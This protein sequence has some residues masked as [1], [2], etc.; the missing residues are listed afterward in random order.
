MMTTTQQTTMT[1]VVQDEY[2]AV[3]EDVLRVVDVER[4]TIDDN[5]VLVAV[6]AAAVD[7]G[8]WHVMAGLPLVG[9]LAFGLRSPRVPVPG[10]DLAG[11]IEAVGKAVTGFAP[12]DEVFGSSGGGSGSFAEY[13]V[14]QPRRLATKPANLSFEQAAAVPI[15]GLTALQAV[16]D[17]GRVQAGM[18]VAVVGASGGVGSYAVQIAKAFGA[19]VTGVA[20]TA[21]LDHVRSLG[22]EHVVDYTREDF[23]DGTVQYDVII[24][25]GGNRSLG[26]LRQALAPQ[27]R[28]V[29]TGGEGGGRWFGGI[30]RQLRAMVLS[31]FVGQ[32]M[33]SFLSSENADD[34]VALR[35]LI[36]AGKV[37]PAIDRTFR[38]ADAA[39]AI[40]Y[41]A[42]GHAQGKVVIAL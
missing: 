26:H 28:L 30:D 12:G 37:V 3:A 27:G 16:R 38:L 21:K 34:L 10:R 8:V 33:G 19:E 39:A 41:V 23:A 9:R 18:K 4:P 31:L 25:I 36:E 17:K 5:E 22:A 29:I 24:D 1:A 6:R 32:K 40:S 42:D 11:T 20:S 35:E 7:R 2:G 13:A 15:S 14:A